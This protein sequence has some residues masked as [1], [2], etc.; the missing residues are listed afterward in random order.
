MEP[1]KDEIPE[2]E[3]LTKEGHRLHQAE[4]KAGG[5][6]RR[7]KA[8]LVVAVVLTVIGVALLWVLVNRR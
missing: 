6:P 8:W 4:R 7:R 5:Y 2:K 3:W 1:G